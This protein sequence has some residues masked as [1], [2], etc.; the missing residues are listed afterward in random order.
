[1]TD[2]PTRWN[3]KWRKRK[4]IGGEDVGQVFEGRAQN[5]ATVRDRGRFCKPCGKWKLWRELEFKYEL[6]EGTLIRLTV[7]KACGEVVAYDNPGAKG[8][9][10]LP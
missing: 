6:D 8:Y 3:P 9:D 2:E 5:V 1:M 7:C 4:K 10:E